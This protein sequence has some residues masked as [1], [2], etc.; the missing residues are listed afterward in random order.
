MQ[1][2]RIKSVFPP[3]PLDGGIIRIGG[4]DYGMAAEIADDEHGHVWRLL[5]LLDGSRT[6]GEVVREMV[7]ADSAVEPDEVEA[8]IRALALGGYLEDA[9]AAPPPDLFSAAEIERYRRNLQFFSFFHL[10]PLTGFDLQARLK[11][12]RVGVLGLGG[13]GSH[14]A[15][16]LAAA[17]VGDLLLVDHDRVEPS[18]LNR[19]VLYTDGDVGSPKAEAAARRIADVNPFIRARGWNLRVSSLED[20][21]AVMAGRDLLVC[22]ADRPRIRIYEWLN[23]AALA[24]GVPWVRGANDGLTVNTFLH[25]PG[26]TACFECEQ[27]RSHEALP[28]YGRAMR[29]AM[30]EIGDRTV[31]PCT[32]PVAGLIGNL[33]ALEVVKWLTGIAR[34]AILGRK[35]TFDLQTLQTRL[36]G[37]ERRPDCPACGELDGGRARQVSQRVLEA[38]MPSN[39]GFVDEGVAPWR[40]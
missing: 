40:P 13:L 28:W 24:E 30:E 3:I 15:L 21:R 6:H 5:G 38:G 10:P 11:R 25:V 12:A 29:Y 39:P 4:A 23:A 35:L 18:N 33:T 14:V 26:E 16:S 9:A 8:S 37:G 1:R 19:Q 32:S 27:L 17:G 7:L 2:P 20:A 36:A 31:N 34:P 22:A